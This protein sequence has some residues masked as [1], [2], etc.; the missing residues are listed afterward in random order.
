V[1]FFEEQGIPT[2]NIA[3]TEF[4]AAARIQCKNLGIPSYEVVTVS[5]PIVPLTKEEVWSRADAVIDLIASKLAMQEMQ[6]AAS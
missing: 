4:V 3:T 6:A 5:H 2:A 1:A